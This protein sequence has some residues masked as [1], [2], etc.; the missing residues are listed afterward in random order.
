MSTF[1]LYTFGKDEVQTTEPVQVD[2]K[3]LKAIG[4]FLLDNVEKHHRLL[5]TDEEDYAVFEAIDKVLIFPVPPDGSPNNRWDTNLKKFV[6][7]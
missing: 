5:I 6:S 7:Q 4:Q 1:T 3:D 2:S